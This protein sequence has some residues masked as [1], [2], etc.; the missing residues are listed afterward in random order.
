MIAVM[1]DEVLQ[2]TIDFQGGQGAA[3]RG[4]T[5]L[6]HHPSAAADHVAGGLVGDRRQAFPGKDGVKGSALMGGV[7]D[8]CTV[9]D[10]HDDWV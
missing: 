9:L 8:H 3:L 2:Q 10:E 4:Q 5:A 1:G 6:D 7:V